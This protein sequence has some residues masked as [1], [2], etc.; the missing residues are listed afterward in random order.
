MNNKEEYK[1]ARLEKA[2]RETFGEDAV[3]NFRGGWNKEKEQF[4]HKEKV[5]LEKRI[6]KSQLQNHFEK[7][8]YSIS[9]KLLNKKDFHEKRKCEICEVFSFELRD[10]YFMNKYE[11]CFECYVNY[12]ENR[13]Q[14]WQN[15]WRPNK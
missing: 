4:F 1:A 6:Y 7:D 8:G 3:Q 15:G 9:E 14:R 5:A 10:S 13:E 12:V 11:C 2:V